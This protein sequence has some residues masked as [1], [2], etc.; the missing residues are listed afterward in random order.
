MVE[1]FEKK[2]DN[3]T[4]RKEYNSKW[5]NQSYKTIKIEYDESRKEYLINTW[6]VSATQY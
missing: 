6:N 4:E 3:Y 5:S 1:V 2:K